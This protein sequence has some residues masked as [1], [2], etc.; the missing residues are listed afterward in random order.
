MESHLFFQPDSA[1][2]RPE[3]LYRQPGL[4]TAI[5]CCAAAMA[6]LLFVDIPALHTQFHPT[7]IR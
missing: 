1:A 7:V 4:M 2:Q 3:T 6:A 5:V